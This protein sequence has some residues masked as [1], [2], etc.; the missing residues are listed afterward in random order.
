MHPDFA[1]GCATFRFEP[2]AALHQDK[3]CVGDVDQFIVDYVACD[4]GSFRLT[5]SL[6][7]PGECPAPGALQIAQGL[8]D[9]GDSNVRCEVEDGVHR[10]VVIIGPQPRPQP[11]E[12]MRFAVSSGLEGE[13]ADYILR[14]TINR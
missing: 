1:Q 3:L 8:Y 10:I 9:C 13:G 7:V 5:V 4:E 11:V 6:T 2:W 12:E 14:A